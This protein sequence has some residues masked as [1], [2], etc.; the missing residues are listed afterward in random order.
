[1][2]SWHPILNAHETEPG[3]WTMIGAF[4]QP[5]ALIRFLSIGG[6]LGYRAVTWAERSEDRELIG[7]YTTLRAACDHAHGWLIA[8]TGPQGFAPNPWGGQDVQTH[9]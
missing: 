2:T 6:E 7:Y 5:Y 9:E 4:E 1:M 3:S 8:H